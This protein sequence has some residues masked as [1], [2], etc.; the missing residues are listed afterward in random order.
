MGD[1]ETGYRCKTVTGKKSRLKIKVYGKCFVPK[2]KTHGQITVYRDLKCPFENFDKDCEEFKTKKLKGITDGFAALEQLHHVWTFIFS[3]GKR[4]E[5]PAELKRQWD[6]AVGGWGREFDKKTRKMSE[7]RKVLI[8][9]LDKVCKDFYSSKVLPL[10]DHALDANTPAQLDGSRRHDA[11]VCN[12]YLSMIPPAFWYSASGREFGLQLARLYNKD[13]YSGDKG[14][15]LALFVGSNSK[16]ASAADL[17][18]STVFESGLTTLNYILPALSVDHKLTLNAKGFVDYLKGKD[19]IRV[20]T[21]FEKL[22]AIPR[23][24]I[25]DIVWIKGGDVK[26]K[27]QTLKLE[28]KLGSVALTNV[29]N[30]IAIFSALEDLSKNKTF[31]NKMK[32]TKAIAEMV[33]SITKLSQLRLA[34]VA[35]RSAGVVGLGLE[36]ILSSYDGARQLDLSHSRDDRTLLAAAHF[37]KAIGCGL[38]VVSLPVGAAIYLIGCLGVSGLDRD[39]YVEWAKY[40][41]FGADEYS[42]KRYSSSR[43]ALWQLE[44]LMK[45]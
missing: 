33:T 14:S 11:Q 25:K 8:Q 44:R 12:E 31:Y 4:K 39:P 16:T 17:L 36:G 10:I 20:R 13:T 32:S 42:S 3:V 24:D 23:K 38:M 35:C 6:E 21:S 41:A 30:T 45:S 28:N 9:N 29:L 19:L 22:G 5:L 18:D 1:G 7:Q 34:R 27:V 37:V 2:V 26:F 15:R 40:T 43:L